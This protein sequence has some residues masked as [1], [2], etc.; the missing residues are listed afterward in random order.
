MKLLMHTMIHYVC[1]GVY[2]S[3]MH[4]DLHREYMYIVHIQFSV[5][6]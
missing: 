3:S 1:S 2:Y 6:W 5:N 4:V